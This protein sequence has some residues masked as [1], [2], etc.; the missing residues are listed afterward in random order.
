MI[1]EVH[2]DQLAK[3]GA[4]GKRRCSKDLAKT[5]APGKDGAK[6]PRGFSIVAATNSLYNQEQ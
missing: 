1:L 6:G 4:P 2:Q 3:D 5:G